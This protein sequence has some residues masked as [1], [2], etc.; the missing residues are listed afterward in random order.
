MDSPPVPR[1]LGRVNDTALIILK[2]RPKYYIV[3]CEQCGTT[4]KTNH[5]IL[6]YR[7][8]GN[9]GPCIHCDEYNK[10]YYKA[11]AP[12]SR[13]LETFAQNVRQRRKNLGLTQ[14]DISL[15]MGLASPGTVNAIERA[16]YNPGLLAIERLAEALDATPAELLS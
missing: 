4:W 1:Q 10:R 15:R 12:M 14:L 3:F 5:D 11:P 16:K 9:R 8:A 6:E 13:L 2:T 7:L